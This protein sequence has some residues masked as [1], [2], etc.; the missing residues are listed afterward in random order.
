MNR[1]IN[2]LLGLLLFPTMG[3]TIFVGFDLPI[4]MLKLSG[5]N[6][7]YKD[8]VF[9]GMGLLILIVIIRRSVR[10][11]MGMRIVNQTKKF[12]W[13]A[14]VSTERKSRVRVYLMLEAFVMIFV[15]VALYLVCETAIAPCIAFLIGALDNTIFA[16][17]GRNGKYRVGI[18]SKA[19][20]VADR[21]VILLYFTGLRKISAHQQTT[22]F[23]YIKGLQL[24]FPT[25]CIHEE[26]RG[27]F[28]KVLEEQIDPNRVFF[29]KTMDDQ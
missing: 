11:W 6:L 15:G 22:Y 3:L 5:N 9:L 19:V 10:R 29:S 25:D 1:S 12:K 18:S 13:N 26:E 28:L 20:I 2:I 24:S 27:E 14:E 23:D 7:P 21:E 17:A 4:E 16:I 8:Y